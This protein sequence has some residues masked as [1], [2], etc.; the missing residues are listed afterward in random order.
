MIH[1][2]VYTLIFYFMVFQA[3]SEVCQKEV[4][5]ISRNSQKRT[6]SVFGSLIEGNQTPNCSI[7]MVGLQMEPGNLQITVRGKYD[8]NITKIWFS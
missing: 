2:L 5:R 7:K 4:G 3:S 8:K 1:Y 6:F